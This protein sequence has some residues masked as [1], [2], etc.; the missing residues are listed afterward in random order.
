MGDAPY[1]A[2]VGIRMS[3]LF[4][5]RLPGPVKQVLPVAMRPD[6]SDSP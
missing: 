4:Y 1:R 2:V 5:R 6:S 3:L